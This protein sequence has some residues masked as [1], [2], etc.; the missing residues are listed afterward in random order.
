VDDKDDKGA[1]EELLKGKDRDR[2]GMAGRRGKSKTS[3]RSMLI[4]ILSRF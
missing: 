4:S 1:G 2:E 3:M